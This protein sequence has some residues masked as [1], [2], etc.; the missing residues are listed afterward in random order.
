MKDELHYLVVFLTEKKKYESVDR[1]QCIPNRQFK[2]LFE[3]EDV[4]EAY[5]ILLENC[6][7]VCD[8]SPLFDTFHQL[9]THMKR[10]HSVFAC[11]LCVSHLKIFPFERKFYSR[12]DLAT[13]RRSGDADNT[14]YRGHPLCRFCDDRYMD[15]D[16][17]LR[18][19]RK[20]HFYCQFC[21]A[22]NSNEYYN[23]YEDLK[24]HFRAKHFLCE[25]GVCASPDARFTHAFNSE[26]DLKAHKTSDHM[27]KRSKA[28]AKELRTIDLHFQVAPRRRGRDNSM[29]TSE[30]FEEV[31]ASSGRTQ[32]HGAGYKRAEMH[33]D[34]RERPD[35]KQASKESS[36]GNNSV[37]TPRMPI[38]EEDFP[39]LSN[40]PPVPVYQPPIK[41][42]AD[43]QEDFPSLLA[44]KHSPPVGAL[45]S[46]PTHPVQ[47]KP[48]PRVASN[49]A[50]NFSHVA[51]TVT[52][53]AEPTQPSRLREARPVANKQAS[54]TKNGSGQKW[55]APL[56]SSGE[57]FPTL[58][59]E[60]KE[61]SVINGPHFVNLG[62][63]SKTQK[64]GNE[65]N[66]SKKAASTRASF[67]QPSENSGFRALSASF[68]KGLGDDREFPLLGGVPTLK[69]VTAVWGED[70]LQMDDKK[71]P[72]MSLSSTLPLPK[73][74][75]NGTKDCGSP[76][77]KSKKKK[78]KQKAKGDTGESVVENG[79]KADAFTVKADTLTVDVQVAVSDQVLEETLHSTI[80]CESSPQ[81]K[82]VV[83]VKQNNNISNSVP[84]QPEESNFTSAEAPM[85]PIAVENL[86]VLE[87]KENQEIFSSPE[88][89]VDDDFPSL[90]SISKKTD[91][92][93]GFIKTQK[94]TKPPP[95][96][97]KPLS[98]ARAPPGLASSLG[99]S[100]ACIPMSVKL[101]MH[102][103]VPPVDIA[104]RNSELVMQIRQMLKATDLDKF[105]KLSGDFRS[106]QISA[107]EYLQQ[108]QDL[109]GKENFCSVL[110]E[111]V[112]LLPDILKQQ[113][114]LL[115]CKHPSGALGLHPHLL[116]CPVC[117]QL[118]AVKDFTPHMVSHPSFAASDHP[119]ASVPQS[120]PSKLTLAT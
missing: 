94:V 46:V 9:E 120:A 43:P 78:K 4:E 51:A 17:L 99:S 18:H 66:A 48:T 47:K 25:E 117:Y 74:Q 12:K 13:H 68:S 96:L 37:Q 111:L 116:S 33:H 21:D 56:F 82:L 83:N 64:D 91:P 35:N 16:E 54:F 32:R 113:E 6:C 86:N 36:L 67:K 80:E 38:L 88:I 118:L 34:V 42:R 77:S 28:E 69:T 79:V 98:Q 60:R 44:Q 7:R 31:S 90:Q 100:S 81:Q 11:D 89:F 55:S 26:I 70:K 119:S 112:A 50:V 3:N 114:L 71:K 58:G 14:S 45:A 49:A 53:S 22:L 110:P 95:G 106:G 52:G 62:A 8:K 65:K 23:D 41:E 115:A 2:I 105:R 92:P 15:S 87:D 10:S 76:D 108:C 57:E 39:S 1:R 30:D 85:V 19:L 24:A 103:F 84:W 59:V 93:P 72:N 104:E 75:I 107:M 29:I 20:D 5:D 102:L 27:G 101:N 61:K 97:K 73:K 109:L 40:T 63:W